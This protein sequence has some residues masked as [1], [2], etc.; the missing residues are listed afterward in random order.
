MSQLYVTDGHAVDLN[1]VGSNCNYTPGETHIGSNGSEWIYVQSTGA[2]T[3]GAMVGINRAYGA[4]PVTG[5]LIGTASSSLSFRV[6]FAQ[7]AFAS[8]QWGFVALNG[9]QVLIRIAGA[10]QLHDNLYTSDTAGTLAGGAATASTSQ[11]Q[12]FGV[13][14]AASVSASGSTATA[15]TANLSWP[16][17]RKPN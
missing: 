4:T 13:Y 6:G 14:L 3:Q 11:F 10:A 2:I 12:M 16:L 8:S 17:M 15:V 5:G 1:T 9:N 7:T